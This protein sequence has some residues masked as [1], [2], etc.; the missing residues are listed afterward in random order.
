VEP[1]ILTIGRE[2]GYLAHLNSR[3]EAAGRR[4]VG[5]AT[6]ADLRAA[7][8][9]PDVAAAVLG[10]ALPPDRVARYREILAE[11]RPDLPVHQHDLSDGEGAF[12]ALVHRA[13]DAARRQP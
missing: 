11:L 9:D 3:I 6:E 2:R 5:A 10:G 12:D 7:L 8:T 4:V 1:L 13:A